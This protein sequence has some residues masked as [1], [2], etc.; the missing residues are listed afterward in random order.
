MGQLSK[1]FASCALLAGY[2]SQNVLHAGSKCACLNRDLH[3]PTQSR[4]G[5]VSTVM[6]EGEIQRERERE[7]ARERDRERERV[8]ERAPMG[9]PYLI[10]W[11]CIKSLNHAIEAAASDSR[12][13]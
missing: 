9:M 1:E 8:R 13:S 6:Q 12:T 10:F 5:L 4:I 2:A 3:R 7:Q 11:L